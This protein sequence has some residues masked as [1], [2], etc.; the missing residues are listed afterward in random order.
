MQELTSC[1]ICGSQ[2]IHFHFKGHTTRNPNDQ[3]IWSVYRCGDCTHKFMNPQP[4]W[5]ELS[6]YYSSEYEAYNKSHGAEANDDERIIQQAKLEG[7]FRH[8]PIPEGKRLLDVGCGGGF[9]LR[10]AKQLGA[11]VKGI[12]PSPIGAECARASGLDVF[13][14]TLEQYLEQERIQE[15]YDIIT[16]NHALEHM[17][18]PVQTLSGMKK[19]LAPNGF[20]W[21]SVPNADCTFAKELGWRWHSTD[22]PYHIMQFNPKSLS[23]AAKLADLNIQRQS[24]Y[25]LPKALSSSLTLLLRYRWLIPQRISSKLMPKKYIDKVA[26]TLDLRGEGEAILTELIH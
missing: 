9:F 17:P 13:N 11:K 23:Q 5:D 10:I 7:Q 16:C 2:D 1:P 8:I 24:T 26:Q 21:L 12:E 18:N 6:V 14:G 4:D 15:Q 25:S 22:L 20:I 19:L 3:K